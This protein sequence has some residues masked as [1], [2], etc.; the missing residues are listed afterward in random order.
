M[1]MDINKKISLLMNEISSGTY[2]IPQIP[3]AQNELSGQAEAEYYA[4][5]R[6]NM[7]KDF[8]HIIMGE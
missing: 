3:Q 5:A 7:T 2:I 1:I 6:C 8:A 4:T